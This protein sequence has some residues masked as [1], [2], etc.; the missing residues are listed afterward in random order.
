LAG[1]SLQGFPQW[2][3]HRCVVA[4]R[5]IQ[6]ATREVEQPADQT[7]RVV[8]D[9]THDDLPFAVARPLSSLDAFLKPPAR[10]LSADELLQVGDAL[11]LTLVSFVGLE[12]KSEAVDK[13]LL[14]ER[15]QS[16]TELV[17]A[18]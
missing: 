6:S 11:I 3:I 8:G 1:K 16:G 12:Y 4:R 18:T 9:E 13:C 10:G 2:S 14:P 15:E 17:Q 5:A 7:S